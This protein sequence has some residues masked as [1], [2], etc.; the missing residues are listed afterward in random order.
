MSNE[1]GFD[2]LSGIVALSNMDVLFLPLADWHGVSEKFESI[3]AAQCVHLV[4]VKLRFDA[5]SDIVEGQRALPFILDND[6]SDGIT[7][8]IVQQNIDMKRPLDFAHLFGIG[9]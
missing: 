2:L 4:R 9:W 8:F 1:T 3:D 7:R 6:Q 5:L